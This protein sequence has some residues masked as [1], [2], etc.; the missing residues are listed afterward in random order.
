MDRLVDIFFYGLYMD[1]GL[2]EERDVY[3]RHP[4][5]ASIK[6]HQL[7]IGN[8]STILRHPG[9]RAYG[10]VYSLTHNEIIKLYPDT[11]QTLY[12]AEALMTELRDGTCIAA[13]SWILL[14][15]P[16][17]NEKN[18]DLVNKMTDAMAKLGLPKID[19]HLH[20]AQAVLGS[21]TRPGG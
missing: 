15:P 13:V 6:D 11:A 2:L 16:A 14:R 9:E 1:P 3:P 4:R 5:L 20:T 19:L 8:Y 18:P 17:P 12:G 21:L 7:C 10:V